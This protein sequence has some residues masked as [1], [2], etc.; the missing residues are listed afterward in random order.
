MPAKNANI[1]MMPSQYLP[2]HLK[3][4]SPMITQIMR[5]QLKQEFE[6]K[7]LHEVRQYGIG[8]IYT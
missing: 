1:I 7:N 5:N 3:T 4:N 6:F 2:F 8:L